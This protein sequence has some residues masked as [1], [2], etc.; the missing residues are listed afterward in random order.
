MSQ[1]IGKLQSCFSVT[2]SL[3]L[4]YGSS[5][6]VLHNIPSNSQY[7]SQNPQ[8]N[9][10]TIVYKYMSF[11]LHVSAYNGLL[12]RDGCQSRKW[13]WIIILEMCGYKS[14]IHVFLDDVYLQEFRSPQKGTLATTHNSVRV[15]SWLL[16]GSK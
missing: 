7:L 10:K 6:S 11:L 13:I 16:P 14:T 3:F 5:Q 4:K 15:Y 9:I 12:H 1:H 2:G 8:N